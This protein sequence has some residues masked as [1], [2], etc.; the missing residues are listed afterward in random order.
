MEHSFTGVNICC[1]DYFNKEGIWPITV[2]DKVRGENQTNDIGK[3]K[4]GV[5]GDARQTQRRIRRCN[6]N[7]RQ[8][9]VAEYRLT[10]MGKLRM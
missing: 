4:G 1:C 10:K 9:H 8:C 7:E 5:R 3:K 2:Q 6:I